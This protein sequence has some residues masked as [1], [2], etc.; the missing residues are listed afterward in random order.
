MGKAI[1]LI[2]DVNDP[3]V[4]SVESELKSL[5]ERVFRFDTTRFASGDT[6]L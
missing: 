4:D 3:E 1:L 5:E 6:T 2:S